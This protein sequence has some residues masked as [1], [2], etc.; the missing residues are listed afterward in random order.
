MTGRCEGKVAIVRGA[1]GPVGKAIANGL[2]ESGA[3]V[4]AEPEHSPDALSLV[5]RV[6]SAHGTVD[7]LVNCPTPVD[8]PASDAVTEEQFLDFVDRYLWDTYQAV[9]LVVPVMKAK[10]SGWILN[11]SDLDGVH[12]LSPMAPDRAPG[13]DTVVTGLLGA[14]LNRVSV[15]MAAELYQSGIA[16]NSLTPVDGDDLEVVADAAVALCSSSKVELTG[17]LAFPGPLVDELR[18]TGLYR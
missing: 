6:V 4:V 1:D 8:S 14:A 5:D 15:A 16:V 17:R 18:R 13:S 2:A 12:P 3:A 9:R 10:R 11:V 7:I